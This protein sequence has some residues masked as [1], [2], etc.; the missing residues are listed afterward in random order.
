MKANNYFETYEFSMWANDK[1][2]KQFVAFVYADEIRVKSS[3]GAD[4][5]YLYMKGSLVAA[6]PGVRVK[7]ESKSF[8]TTEDENGSYTGAYF[9]YS[10]TVE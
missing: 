6:L 8:A 3:D 1:H 9:K 10:Y 2:G 5:F 7:F 4:W